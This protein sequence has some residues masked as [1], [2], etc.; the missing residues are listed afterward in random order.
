MVLMINPSP[1]RCAR[2]SAVWGR[3]SAPVDKKWRRQSRELTSY[4]RGSS[5]PVTFTRSGMVLEQPDQVKTTADGRVAMEHSGM[6][7]GLVTACLYGR[8]YDQD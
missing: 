5:E 1:S 7:V 6:T 8:V 2:W 4:W 3:R